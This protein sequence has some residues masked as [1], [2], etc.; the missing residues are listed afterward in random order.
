MK[1]NNKQQKVKMFQI[2][3]SFTNLNPIPFRKSD[4]DSRWFKRVNSIVKDIIDSEFEDPYSLR[5]IEVYSRMYF[6]FYSRKEVKE[7]AEG[8]D[9]GLERAIKDYTLYKL[10]V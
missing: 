4:M 10:A 1:A 7:T 8:W 6:Q 2:F 9:A 5:T 3:D